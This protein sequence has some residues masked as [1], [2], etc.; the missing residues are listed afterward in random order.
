VFD[1]GMHNGEDSAYY[2]HLGY[3]VVGV[4]A[5]PLQTAACAMRFK[6]EIGEGRMKIINAGVLRQPGEFT[7]YRNLQEDAWSSFDPERG[8]KGG[9]WEPLTISC[10]TARQLIAAEGKPYFMKVDIE[11]ADFQLIE[12]MTPVMAPDY[13]SL[14]LSPVDP[15]IE[16]LIA[17]GY[18]CFKFVDGETYR[19]TPQIL[20]HQIGWRLLRKAGRV[21]P[22]IRRT[23]RTLPEPLRAKS[24]FNPPGRY[25]P[26]GYVFTSH[27]SGPFGEQAAGSWLSGDAALRW[28]SH[29]K[30]D[31][32]K[33]DEPLWWDVHARHSS[34]PAL[35]P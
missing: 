1:V 30:E 9:K 35:V 5:N 19:P 14:E 16:E 18:S 17:L 20:R 34:V 27:S 3:S 7:F 28:F 22:V 8:Q 4:E 6:R 29:V 12:S 32:R 31:Y 11:G 2:L 15:I 25:S 24:E 23:I 26:D 10:M 21:A 33:A 13:I